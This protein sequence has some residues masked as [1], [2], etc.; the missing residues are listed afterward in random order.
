MTSDRLSG[1]LRAAR[2]RAGSR[3]K[4]PS[5]NADVPKVGRPGS[6]RAVRRSEAATHLQTFDS[7]LGAAQAGGEWAWRV[8]YDEYFP[9]L[10]GYFRVQ[11]SQDPENL[12][13]DVLLRM[14]RTIHNFAGSEGKFR[15]WV[16]T[17]AHNRLI[18]E[19]RKR[20]RK[21]ENLEDE[22]PDQPAPGHTE[23]SALARLG[24]ESVVEALGLLS[25]DQR[26]VLALRILNSF[27]IAEIAEV[28]G[29][30]SGA[31][32]ALQRRALRRLA[33]HF[34]TAPYPFDHSERSP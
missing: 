10:V 33:K 6:G 20:T 15:S 30:G 34:K 13:G 22:L 12:A 8:L 7:I 3:A 11:G 19:R 14:S 1:R 21:P 23:D 2:P 4:L 16:F 31:V 9:P 29:K 24:T 18:D 28:T 5:V 26:E 25:A 32:K 17:I 27:T